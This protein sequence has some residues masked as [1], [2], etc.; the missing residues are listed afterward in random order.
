MFRGM[1]VSAGI[2]LG[3]VIVIKKQELKINRELVGDRTA[4]WNRYQQAEEKVIM[5]TQKL[6]QEAKFRLSESDMVFFKQQM[7]VLQ[8]DLS[9]EVSV[10][11]RNNGLSAEAAVED[12]CS[13]WEEKVQT[14]DGNVVDLSVIQDL[15]IRLLEMLMGVCEPDFAQIPKDSILVVENLTS[16]AAAGLD[17]KR[18]AG[19]V[20]E[21][22]GMHSHSAIILRE[23]EIPAV[24]GIIGFLD[25]ISDGDSMILDGNEGIV[26]VSPREV[27]YHK[28]EKKQ[29]I[30]Q[31]QQKILQDYVN[32]ETVTEDGQTIALYG[33]IERPSD[34]AKVLANG[35]EGVGLLRTEFLFL[36]RNSLP[37]E[38]EQFEAYCK[39]AR[40][41]NGK[42][43]VIRTLDIGG[44]KE[45]P[46]FGLHGEANPFLGYRAIRFSLG[47]MDIF[48]TQLKAILRASA[49]GNLQVMFPMVTSLEELQRAKTLLTLM[50]EELDTERI[51]YDHNIKIGVMIET[52]AAALLSDIF[53]KEVDFVSIGTNDLIQYTMAVDRGNRKVSY[54]YSHYHPAVLRSIR[55]IIK[56]VKAAGKKVAM[57]GE[58][59]GDLLLV[60]LLIAFGLEE[61]SVTPSL[62]LKLRKTLSELNT[63][64]LQQ[65]EEEVMQ[66]DNTDAVEECLRRYS[67][68]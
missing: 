36:D 7:K 60:P 31:K 38:D 12:V 29:Q 16:S 30:Q 51:A 62:I 34:I 13:V 55:M 14:G 45:V 42:P 54:L 35:G 63:Q 41:L 24:F 61:F 4:E 27:T 17:P 68:G 47:R 58:A 43:L 56:N 33:N 44:D 15:K 50:K 53:A 49:Y 2:G 26:Y 5:A 39:A 37:N 28:Y 67:N 57:C 8:E 59:A 64:S 46:Y 32:K 10:K 20:A 11:I 21:M 19:V 66:L 52:P 40:A 6:L 22:G 48:Q 25:F 18:V 3:K 65:L 23:L 9:K 1:G